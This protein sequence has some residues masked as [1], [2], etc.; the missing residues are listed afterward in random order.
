MN[1]PT[2]LGGLYALL[3]DDGELT[4]LVDVQVT[5]GQGS[6]LAVALAKVCTQPT[7]VERVALELLAPIDPDSRPYVLAAA[8]GLMTAKILGPLVDLVQQRFGWNVLD[9]LPA[10]MQSPTPPEAS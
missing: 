10:D 3:G 1:E 8:L 5:L 4:G 6:E 9:W 2:D 7:E